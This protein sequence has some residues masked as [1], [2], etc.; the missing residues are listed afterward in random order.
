VSLL[1]R[2]SRVLKPDGAQ[3]IFRVYSHDPFSLL[4][5]YSRAPL[6]ALAFT[7]A[8]SLV[9][10]PL[11]PHAASLRISLLAYSV[12]LPLR[13]HRLTRFRSLAVDCREVSRGH[14]THFPFMPTVITTH[15]S[16]AL[17]HA[18]PQGIWTECYVADFPVCMAGR[19][20]GRPPLV[21]LRFGLNICLTPFRSRLAA[22][23][24][25]LATYPGLRSS[26][27]GLQPPSL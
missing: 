27:R 14:I 26:M 17:L 9:W 3:L 5:P 10:A 12:S 15:I 24:L 4:F 8:P 2:A 21:R 25:R 19:R 1:G 16:S 13:L 6:L 7:K 23:T 18:T 22:D 20:C 11:T